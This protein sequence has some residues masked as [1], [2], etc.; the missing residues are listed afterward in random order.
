MQFFTGPNKIQPRR[1]IDR[2]GRIETM[3]E[4]A[5]GKFFFIKFT[6]KVASQ[7][8]RMLG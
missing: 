4:Y 1:R 5:M 2:Y 8:P 3:H 6:L 7:N